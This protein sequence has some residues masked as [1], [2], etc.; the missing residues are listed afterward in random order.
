MSETQASISQHLLIP[1]A[2]TSSPE[3]A[4][5]VQA[6]R[7]PNLNQLLATLTLSHSD[8]GTAE[9][10]SP[11][12][13]R[14]LARLQDLPVTDGYIPWA[15]QK[16]T[17]LALPN[18][19]TTAWSFVTLCQCTV[20]MNDV[21]LQNPA[22]LRVTE[23]ESQTL[24]RDMQPYFAEDG[25]TLHALANLPNTWLVSGKPLRDMRTASI[26]RV[27]GKNVDTWQ[28]KGAESEKIHRL[29][30]EMQML[31]YT[32]K[33]NDA[34]DREKLTNINSIWFHGSGEWPQT[35][36]NATISMPKVLMPRSLA[37]AAFEQDWQAW[38]TAWEELDATLC[39][40]MLQRAN[41][42]ESVCLTL[43]G[44]RHAQSYTLQPKTLTT[45]LSAK[46]LSF[47]GIQPAYLLP[48]KL[49]NL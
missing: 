35:N 18:A 26:D 20:G 43:C 19:Q 32:H 8:M 24:L 15:A 33:V 34:R 22:L 48:K 10:F 6:L 25:L 5:H 28:T 16:A 49:L 9:S 46:V 37:N 7:L 23:G 31:L 30:N 42:G 44:Q 17:A 3:A 38:A 39:A 40:D 12:H 29:Q 2:A 36:P 41:S 14:A 4:K 47:L 45:R 11:P 1:L 13:E 27:I 21:Q